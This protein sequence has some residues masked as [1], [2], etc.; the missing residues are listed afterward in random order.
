MTRQ[1]LAADDDRSGDAW[2]VGLLAGCSLVAVILA[3][4][5]A[6]RPHSG[7]LASEIAAAEFP[8]VRAAPQAVAPGARPGPIR[9]AAQR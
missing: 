2:I 6:A 8:V 3:L 1:S 9:L 7:R 5:I 4:V